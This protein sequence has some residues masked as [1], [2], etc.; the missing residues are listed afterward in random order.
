MPFAKYP[1]GTVVRLK[2]TGE[3]ALIVGHNLMMDKPD[4]F[5]NYY[6]EI[7]G[8]CGRWVT[9]DD[10]IELECFPLFASEPDSENVRKT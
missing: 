10:R 2:K 7:E 3:F 5:L 8:K 1:I 4:T 6:I 9:Y